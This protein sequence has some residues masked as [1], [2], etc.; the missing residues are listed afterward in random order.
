MAERLA[1][2]KIA[3]PVKRRKAAN[4]NKTGLCC[5]PFLTP[6]SVSGSPQWGVCSS[7]CY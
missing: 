2:E 5:A 1:A 4:R 3:V 6:G 7:Q